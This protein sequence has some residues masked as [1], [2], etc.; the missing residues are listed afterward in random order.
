MAVVGPG[1][2][3]NGIIINS[4]TNYNFMKTSKLVVALYLSTLRDLDLAAKGRSIASMVKANKKFADAAMQAQADRVLALAE[5]LT[6]AFDLPQGAVGRAEQLQRA[7]IALDMALSGLGNLVETMVNN[8]DLTLEDR[9]L[10][11]Q[12]AGMQVKPTGGR[13]KRG[14]TVEQGDLP[15]SAMCHASSDRA[16]AH[17]WQIAEDI[18]NLE[19]RVSLPATTKSTTLVTDLKPGTEYAFYHRPVKSGATLPWEGPIFFR[20]V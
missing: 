13:G 11:V 9:L 5:E 18:S 19:V 20:V 6:Q 17:E 12:E 7:R 1:E 3:P 8:E 16:Q 4:L 10:L 14:F 15:G 2:L